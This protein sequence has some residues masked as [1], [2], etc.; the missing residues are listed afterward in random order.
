MGIEIDKRDFRA[1]C[2]SYGKNLYCALYGLDGNEYFSYKHQKFLQNIGP[3]MKR[4]TAIANRFFCPENTTPIDG[5]IYSNVN[6]KNYFQQIFLFYSFKILIRKILVATFLF[7]KR[8]CL[9][10]A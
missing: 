6:M 1:G 4:N 5:I 2:L 8:F 7:V 10:S 3:I 9:Q